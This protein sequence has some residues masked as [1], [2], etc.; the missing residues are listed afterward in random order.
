LRFRETP[1]AGAYVVELEP[2]ADDRGFFAR[3][4][5]DAEFAAHGLPSRWPQCNLS[6]NTRARTL[7][8]LH[9]NAAPHSEAKLVRCVRGAAWD[10]IVDLRAGSPTR[11]QWF[12]VELTAE[13]GNAVYVPQGFVHG[14]VTLRDDSDVFYQMGASYVPNAARGLRWND[15]RF[16]ITWPVEPAVISERD[17][18][19]P[20][21]DEARFDG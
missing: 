3:A 5:C 10:V 15:P 13:A 2:S 18:T 7:R 17:R 8:G 16:G 19:Y 21:F 9:Y 4:Y 20:D 6:R 14:F 11:L 1:L 12:G